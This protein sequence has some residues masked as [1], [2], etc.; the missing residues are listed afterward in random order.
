MP[1]HLV[2]PKSAFRDV[3]LLLR[4]DEE[5][6]RALDALFATSE[7]ISPSSAGFIQKV[8]DRLHLETSAVQSIVLVC[9][10]LLAV[11]EQG[12]PPQEIV[13]DVSE[14]VAQNAQ[15]DE[16]D[17]VASVDAK[18]KALE[19]LLTPKPARSKALKVHYLSEFHPTVAA[20]RTVCELRPVFER[21]EGREEIVSYVPLVALEAR[22]DDSED[23]GG[24]VIIYLS[25]EKLKSL[26]QVIS[27]AEEKLE[28]I[29]RHFGNNIISDA[30]ER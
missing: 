28:S 14:F 20:F 6:L 25:P 30:V 17:L 15:N 3:R 24:R 27:R 8:G 5:K 21:I 2:L 18:R 26:A 9:Q 12:H 19:S 11:V 22:F 4:L 10:F 7:S 13:D 1:K 23:S 16:K 29:R